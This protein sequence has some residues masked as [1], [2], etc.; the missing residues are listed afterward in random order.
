MVEKEGLVVLNMVVMVPTVWFM[1][2]KNGE[3]HGTIFVTWLLITKHGSHGINNSWL[4]HN[5]ESYSMVVMVSYQYQQL[6]WFWQNQQGSSI[7][8]AMVAEGRSLW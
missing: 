1:D 6:K 3:H 7:L 8:V 4:L 5:Y 2:I